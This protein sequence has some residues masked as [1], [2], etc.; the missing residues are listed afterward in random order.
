MDEASSAPSFQV[1]VAAWLP[2]ALSICLL[3]LAC[4][5][6]TPL[7]QEA[8]LLSFLPDGGLRARL[9]IELRHPE[10]KR[11]SSN[12]GRRVRQTEQEL[13]AGWD[14]WS[15]RFGEAGAALEVFHWEKEAGRLV[16]LERNLIL[17]DPRDLTDLLADTPIHASYSVEDGVAELNLYP[18]AP[19]RASRRERRQVER[20]VESWSEHLADYLQALEKLYRHLDLAPDRTLPCFGHL[21]ESDDAYGEL[22]E[23]EELLLEAIGDATAELL[24]VLDVDAERAYSL[25][26][27]SRKV[28]DP[29]PAR[30]IIELP[31]RS[32]E[33]GGFLPSG[34]QWLV[35]GLSLWSALKQLVPAADPLTAWVAHERAATDK[36]FDVDAF[37][38]RDRSLSS[39]TEP[40]LRNALALALAPAD[41]YRVTWRVA[42]DSESDR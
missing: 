41:V 34:E 10:G 32:L 35:P 14:P 4:F 1:G 39:V 42:R 13:L 9:T 37:A 36:P 11:A 19:D 7:V 18:G 6:F 30:F 23:E 25:D 38:A 31:S 40:E 3:L 21:F 5:D 2:R 12:L 20:T 33:A 27:L 24:E 15:K 17:D 26:E 29:F 28:F 16:Y 22:T 8:L